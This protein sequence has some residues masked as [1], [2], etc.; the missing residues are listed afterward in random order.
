MPGADEQARIAAFGGRWPGQEAIVRRTPTLIEREAFR[1]ALQSQFEARVQ[2]LG[3]SVADGGISV[4]Q[5]QGLMDRATS[6]Y[7]IRQEVL[8]A[9]STKIDSAAFARLDGEIRR[10]QAFISRFADQLAMRN[11]EGK[12]MSAAAIGSRATSYSGAGRA[13]GARAQER[14]I[15]LEA[16]EVWAYI[17]IDDA[18]TCFRCLEAEGFYEAGSGPYPGDVCLGRGHCRCR[19]EKVF[20]PELVAA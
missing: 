15:P 20:R 9:G 1:D 11:A 6:Q 4:K 17:A 12:P 2:A 3:K 19:R 5:W 16:G 8:G 13:I 14:T 18:V 10:Q 7:L